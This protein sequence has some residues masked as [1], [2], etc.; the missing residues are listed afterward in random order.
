MGSSNSYSFPINFTNLLNSQQDMN[1]PESL[2]SFSPPIQISSSPIPQFSSQ[3]SDVQD[4]DDNT[5]EAR[6]RWT[7]QEDVVLISGWL[8]TSKDPVVSN[9]Q[10]LGSFWDRIAFYYGAS[11]AVA[12]KPKRGA[13]Q[14][15]QRWKKINETVNK[16]VGC[17]NQA[18]S[19]RSSGQSEDDVLQ[20][21]N[22]LYFNDQKVKFNLEHAWR[23]L[24]HEQKWCTSNAYRGYENSKRTKLDVSGTYSSSSNTTS[25]VEEETEERPPGVK[26]SKSKTKKTARGEATQ[27]D[28][29]PKLQQAWEIRE[30][31]IAA[32][33]RISK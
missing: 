5:K 16:F 28:S 20:M 8:N 17:Y 32:R 3:F 30:K 14:C 22:E 27:G 6:H 1:N 13:S 33:E 21:A 25:R 26:A 7:P 15:K 23:E 4:L 31:E 18:S 11:E 9:G 2:P 29:L 24:R 12:G 19:R 10:K